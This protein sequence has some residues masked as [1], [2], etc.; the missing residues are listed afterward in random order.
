[1]LIGYAPF[2]SEET[3]EV[4]YKVLNWKKYLKIPDDFTLSEEAEDLINKMINNQEER[5]GKNGIEEIKA[6]PFFKGID[7]DNIRNT[8]APFIP[9]IKNDYDTKYFENFEIEEPFYPPKKKYRKRKDI[10]FL[11]YTYKDGIDDLYNN[12][13][14]EINEFYKKIIHVLAQLIMSLLKF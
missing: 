2:C 14:N 10:E 13:D 11:G 6:H 12:N 8:K 3:K 4:C 7:W 5:L 1:M 9:D